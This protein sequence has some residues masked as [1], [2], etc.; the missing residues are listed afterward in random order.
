MAEWRPFNKRRTPDEMANE[1]VQL[2]QG[3][4]TL[5]AAVAERCEQRLALARTHMAAGFYHWLE[6]GKQ[7]KAIKDDLG[8]RCW[9]PWL[10]ERD[11]ARATADRLAKIAEQ[12]DPILIPGIKMEEL[13]FARA[14]ADPSARRSD[15]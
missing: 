8:S 1:V 5:D 10:R 3:E 14:T 4:F 2:R 7:F 13:T 11:I 9:G 6:A 12:F 15:R